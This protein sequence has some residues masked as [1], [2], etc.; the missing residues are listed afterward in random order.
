MILNLEIMRIKNYIFILFLLTSISSCV[1]KYWPEIEKYENVLVVDGLLTNGDDPIIVRLSISSSINDGELLPVEGGELYITDQDQM[2]MPLTEMGSG[3][4]QVLDS[5][6]HGQVGGS[7]QLHI[8]LPNGRNYVSDIC[9][10]EE[11]SPI[12]SVYGVIE[13]SVVI[14]SSHILKGIQFYI[15]NHTN[16]TDTSYYMWRLTQTFKYQATFSL[17]YTWEG[18]YIPYPN[19]DSLRTCWF[20]S[21]VNHI[22]TFST[23][24]LDEPVIKRLPLNYVSTETKRLS[25]RYSLLVKQL[26]LSKSAFDFW[27]AIQ[28]Q[29][30]EHGNLYS[31][32]PI[33]IKGNMQNVTNAEETV[34]GYFT[35]A[36]STKKRIYIDR[37]PL[38]YYYDECTPDFES[39]R[40]IRFEPEEFWP[41]Y[42]TNVPSKGLAMGNNEACF[43]CRLEG[44]SL[45]PPDFWED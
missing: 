7:Y 11:P 1:E 45:T 25:I 43:D 2:E 15:D 39:M 35:V 30:I 36:G 42:L 38:D 27:N 10:L 21:Q 18:E 17:D 23:E 33:Q 20:T 40:N 26:S 29:N 32:Q 9:H 22:F 24:Y 14:N 19:P 5:S 4:Y 37:Q 16:L 31:H 44:G 34:L 6:F 3:I 28:Q 8:S 41:I 13:S 12:D